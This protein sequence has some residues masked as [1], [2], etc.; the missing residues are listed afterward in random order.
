MPVSRTRPLTRFQ[1]TPNALHTNSYFMPIAITTA[2]M[3]QSGMFFFHGLALKYFM[4][5]DCMLLFT[6]QARLQSLACFIVYCL[7]ELSF[8]LDRDVAVRA[9]NNASFLK[10]PTV[11]CHALDCRLVLAGKGYTR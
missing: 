7:F 1:A 3:A 10:T 5:F 2:R 9:V 8:C 6:K 4:T 11:V